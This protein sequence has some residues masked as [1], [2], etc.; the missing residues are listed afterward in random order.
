MIPQHNKAA[1]T[2]AVIEQCKAF[3]QDHPG[4]REN[5]IGIVSRTLQDKHMAA[6]LW[7]QEKYGMELD[8]HNLHN[9]IAYWDEAR[10]LGRSMRKLKTKGKEAAVLVMTEEN[11]E[12]FGPGKF[13]PPQ[14]IEYFSTGPGE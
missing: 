4:E 14:L 2:S 5:S 6:A 1:A 13:K 3:L 8:I 11:E 12:T 10:A 7:M 9:V